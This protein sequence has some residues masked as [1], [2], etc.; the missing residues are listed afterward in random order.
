MDPDA[1]IDR[2][3]LGVGSRL[4]TSDGDPE[5]R[6]R[7]QARRRR[8]RTVDGMPAIKRIDSP[9]KVLNPG[10]KRL[11][12]VYDDRGRA[13]ADVLSTSDETIEVGRP[14][15]LHHHARPD[16]D[17]TVTV[18]AVD[19]LL[20]PVVD[21]GT[22]VDDGGGDALGRPGGRRSAPGGRHR[23]ARSRRAPA[24]TPAH[25]PRVDHRR[26]VRA[27]RHPAG[28][29][30][31]RLNIW[32]RSF[33]GPHLG[34]AFPGVARKCAQMRPSGRRRTRGTAAICRLFRS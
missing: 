4:A 14:L 5:P 7:V 25:V 21:G 8:R 20:V 24:G 3:V 13:T 19:E 32:A 22:I 12:R 17:R 28:P 30:D 1:V 16:V 11:W 33:P 29:P 34:A 26:P 15:H 27:A 31:R 6:R 18:D 2:L 9:V 10:A 23:R